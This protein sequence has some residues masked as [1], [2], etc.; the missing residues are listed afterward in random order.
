MGTCS[1]QA[2]PY[3]RVHI[4]G[5]RGRMEI[6]I[7]FNPPPER[8]CVIAIDDGSNLHGEGIER[9]ELDGFDQYTIQ[10]ISSPRRSRRTPRYPGRWRMPSRTWR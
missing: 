3:Q 5:S 7:P 2:V 8:P 6:E 1:I 10:G 9:V 4:I